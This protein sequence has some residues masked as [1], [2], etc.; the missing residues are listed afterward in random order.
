VLRSVPLFVLAAIGEI[1]SAGLV[2]RCPGSE[3]GL[4]RRWVITLGLDGF[5]QAFRSGPVL[6][7]GPE[8]TRHADLRAS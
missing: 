2:S 4:D 7:E 8:R 6:S 1:G 3:P 5:V